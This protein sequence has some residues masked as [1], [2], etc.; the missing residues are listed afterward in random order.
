[1]PIPNKDILF[2]AIAVSLTADSSV[3]VA[4][5]MAAQGALILIFHAVAWAF[6]AIQEAMSSGEGDATPA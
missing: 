4:A 5:L 2:A 1:M 3:E 6:A